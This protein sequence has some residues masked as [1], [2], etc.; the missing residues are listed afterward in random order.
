MVKYKVITGN[1]G[2]EMDVRGY[3]SAYDA[4]SGKMVW[5]FFTVPGDPRLLPESKPM[6]MAAK[7]WTGDA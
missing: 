3:V 6:E 1:G 4:A 2:A 5:R 7:T